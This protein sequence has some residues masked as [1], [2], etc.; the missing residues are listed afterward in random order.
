MPGRRVVSL[1]RA[2]ILILLIRSGLSTL[3]QVIWIKVMMMI[4]SHNDTFL[5]RA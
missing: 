3:D 1:P 2:V 5:R 4:S